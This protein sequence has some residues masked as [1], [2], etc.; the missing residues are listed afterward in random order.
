MPGSMNIEPFGG[1]FFA[2][3]YLIANRRIENL[4]AAAGD[5][6]QPNRAQGFQCIADRHPK[7]PLGQMPDFDR[8]EGLDVKFA[9]ESVQS[10]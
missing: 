8:G 9:I 6:A 7:N 5:R 4:C 1:G 3:A 10:L 2:A